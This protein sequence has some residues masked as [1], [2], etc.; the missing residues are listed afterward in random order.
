[1]MDWSGKLLTIIIRRPLVDYREDESSA[2]IYKEEDFVG[3][4]KYPV[5]LGY[6][7]FKEITTFI[8]TKLTQ[9]KRK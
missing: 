9:W 3:E 7:T 6:M 1:M 2:E 5:V 8:K 4:K